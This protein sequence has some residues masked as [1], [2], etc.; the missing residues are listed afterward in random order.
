MTTKQRK[1]AS[2]LYT[3][4]VPKR[5]D[6][7]LIAVTLLISI[8]FHRVYSMSNNVAFINLERT[9]AVALRIMSSIRLLLA[10]T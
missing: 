1:A 6:T 7:K 3:H 4:R 2:L 5:G 9:L 8:D 10:A